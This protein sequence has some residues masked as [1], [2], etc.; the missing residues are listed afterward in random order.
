MR[1]CSTTPRIDSQLL[2]EPEWREAVGE[3]VRHRL[4]LGAHRRGHVGR[5]DT[6]HAGADEAVK[7]FS[8]IEG[9]DEP[10]VLG[11]VRHDAHLDL[12]VV[13]SEQGVEALPRNERG[14]HLPTDFG[15]DRDVLQVRV[16][17]GQPAGRR[18]GLLVVGVHATV[19]A[20]AF[21]QGLDD[22]AD[23][24]G[25]PM[26]Q[27]QLQERMRVQ[28]LQVLQR[29]RIG[30]EAGLVR[31][32]L[33]HAEL[34]EQHLL[35]LL[36]RAEVHL[37]ADLGVG[38]RGDVGSLNTE[39][40]VEPREHG[41]GHRDALHLHAC[42]HRAERHLD[43]VQHP[44]R[45]RVEATG[46]FDRKPAHEPG[47]ARRAERLGLGHELVGVGLR[48]VLAEVV[49]H[50]R[51]ERLGLLRGAQEPGLQ[52]GIQIDSRKLDAGSG[53]RLALALRVVDVLRSGPGEPGVQNLIAPGHP[54]RVGLPRDADAVDAPA[55]QRDPHPEGGGTAVGMLLEPGFEVDPGGRLHRRQLARGGA[56]ILQLPL[57][58]DPLDLQ[59]PLEKRLELQPAEELAHGV[60]VHRGSGEVGRGQ[61]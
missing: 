26:L 2:A 38:T 45:T 55:D 25:I 51:R 41:R 10:G 60:H 49:V 52:R 54:G 17:R 44:Q 3:A 9:F 1:A 36:R 48:E 19:G 50:E 20:E 24:G 42:E 53:Q 61:R 16:V 35:Q 57:V 30:R 28:V 22:L 5:V 56:A 15:L 18:T 37:A 32:G 23:L 12:R 8:R 47:F 31:P 21:L 34:V 7:V 43:V 14:P 46:E 58:G 11:E 4:H 40:L 13:G 59:E 27:Q 39:S 29:L 33:G 6:E